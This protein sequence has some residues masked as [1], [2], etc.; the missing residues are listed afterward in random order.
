MGARREL[1]LCG[2]DRRLRGQ[3]ESRQK[4]EE[5]QAAHRDRL[6]QREEDQEERRH[7]ADQG[8]HRHAALAHHPLG[9]AEG[10]GG[11]VGPVRPQ[12][13]R[14]R[15]RTR[16]GEDHRRHGLV[17]QPHVPHEVEGLGRGG[18]GPGQDGQRQVPPGRH[19]VLRGALDVA[20]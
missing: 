1:R 19:S 20:H 14:L 6:H 12:G 2:L 9:R 13:A 15:P 10:E 7:D 18:L 16:A 8:Q 5:D 17:R 4:R 11:R 3:G